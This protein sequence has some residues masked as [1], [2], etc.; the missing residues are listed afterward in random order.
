MQ[1][2]IQI[3]NVHANQIARAI[4]DTYGGDPTF[5]GVRKHLINHLRQTVVERARRAAVAQ[6]TEALVFDAEWGDL[7]E[8]EE[9]PEER[10]SG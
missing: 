2:V 9:E 4:A 8:V 5:E 6:A 3:P 10:R 1:L 7:E